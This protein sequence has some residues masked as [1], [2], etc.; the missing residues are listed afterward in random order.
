[1]LVEELESVGLKLNVAKTVA[2]T[3]QAQPP[4]FLNT[5][6]GRTIKRV[7]SHRWLG[8][9]LNFQSRE[10][11]L[12][13]HL[14]AANKAFHANKW[15]LKDKHVSLVQRLDYFNKVITPVA[16]FAAG[17]RVVY[18]SD[19]QKLDVAYRKLIRQVCG[20]P[21]NID[22][23]RPWHEVLHDWNEKVERV[24]TN[25]NIQ[26]WSLTCL[27]HYW[28][29]GAYCANLP[30]DR[31]ALGPL[32]PQIAGSPTRYVGNGNGFLLQCALAGPLGGGSQRP[33]RV[34]GHAGRSPS[35]HDGMSTHE[36]VCISSETDPLRSVCGHLL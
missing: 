29:F 18:Q 9:I 11:A 22:W 13:H 1:M 28:K 31:W 7:C 19:L 27:R 23:S 6:E 34:A 20:P 15:L 4:D 25:A 2:L 36:I 33:T 14:L 5:P 32:R 30:D 3:T 12:S 10:E 26:P 21:G 17:R 16:C 24:T 35:L 8:C